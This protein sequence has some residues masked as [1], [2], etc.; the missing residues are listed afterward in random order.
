MAENINLNCG[1]LESKILLQYI[2]DNNFD[3]GIAFDGDGDRAIFINKDYGVIESDKIMFLFFSFLSSDILNSHIV[4]TEICNKGLEDNVKNIGHHL[5]QTKVGDRLVVEEA[6]A[7][8]ALI[9][10]EPSGHYFFPKNSNTMDG[11]VAIFHFLYL[12][13]H[14]KQDF[15]EVIRGLTHYKRIEENLPLRPT[16][17]LDIEAIRNYMMSYINKTEEKL[18]IRRSMWDPVLRIY[19]DYRE[20]NNFQQLQDVI[21][22]CLKMS[23]SPN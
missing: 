2:Q 18:V 19:Y 23:S 8:S 22:D 6:I 16:E 4:T 14:Y 21:I 1:A 15:L 11:L 12:L 7:Q 20:K 17:K 3:Y 13:D 9:G 10:G 5:V